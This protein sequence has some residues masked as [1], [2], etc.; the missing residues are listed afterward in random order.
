LGLKVREEKASLARYGSALSQAKY[1]R[2][3]DVQVLANIS[4]RRDFAAHGWFETVSEEDAQW[5][6]DE[7]TKFIDRLRNHRPCVLSQEMLDRARA[8]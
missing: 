2:P 4:D 1:L 5:V 6:I 3:A 7:S 8:R